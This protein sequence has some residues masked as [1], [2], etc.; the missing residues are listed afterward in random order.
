MVFKVEYSVYDHYGFLSFSF[1]VS[2]IINILII[3]IQRTKK[4][5]TILL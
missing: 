2:L 3:C 1:E 5:L 4:L